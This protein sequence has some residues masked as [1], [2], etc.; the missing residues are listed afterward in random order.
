M[1]KATKVGD[2]TEIKMG[3]SLDGETVL[4]WVAAYL[5]D[6]VLVDTGCDYSKN[7]LAEFLEDKP[8]SLIINTHHHEDHVGGNALLA[9]ESGL[10][11]LAHPEAI[12][13]MSRKYDLYPFQAEIWGYPEPS[14]AAPIGAVVKE[15]DISLRVIATPGHCRD[16]IALFDEKRRVLFSGDIWVGE[17]PKVARAEEDVNQLISDLRKF[18]ELKPKIMFASLGKVVP[19]PQQVIK[20]TRIYLEETR[21]EIRRLHSEGKPSE[22][23]LAELFGRESMLAQATQ[24][25]LSTRIFIESLLRN[26]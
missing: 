14:T 16:H 1:L 12:P 4:Y 5:I 18:E 26:A 21:D 13:L 22:Q 11:A 9:R 20:R 10:K 19:E 15:G 3:R 25:Q 7:E 23:I 8:V 2:V 6:G 17:R 24:N